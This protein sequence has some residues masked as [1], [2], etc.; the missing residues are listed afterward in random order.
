MIP[1]IAGLL[2]L[3]L[4]STLLREFV[5]A[6]PAAIARRLKQGGGVVALGAAVLMLLRGQVELAIGLAGVGF[7]LT[8]GQT[9]PNWASFGRA[10]RGRA[11]APR[12]TRVRSVLI[13]MELDH[14]SGLMSGS[15]VAGP[16]NGRS[17]DSIALA[18][19]VSLQRLCRSADPEGGRLLEAYLD[20]RSPGWRVADEDQRNAGADEGA[21]GGRRAAYGA[22][23]ENEAYELLGLAKGARREEIARAHRTLMKRF[24]PDHGGSTDMAARVNEAKDVLMR[25]HL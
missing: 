5:R 15:V 21:G 25:R 4:G 14:A 24:H 1:I 9:T 6:N 22:M 8:S 16:L 3:W 7:W 18:D 12:V 2:L 10:M 11:S 19:L 13:A 20:R 23:S 17:L